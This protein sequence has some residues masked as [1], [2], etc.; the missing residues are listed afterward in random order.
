MQPAA[1]GMALAL[2]C[3]PVHAP[4]KPII[5][6]LTA[7][8][9]TD[10]T[11]LRAHLV[12]QIPRPVVWSDCIEY[13]RKEQVKNSIFIGPGRA[14]A[15]LARREGQMGGW[16]SKDGEPSKAAGRGTNQVGQPSTVKLRTRGGVKQ[17][18]TPGV[19]GPGPAQGPKPAEG[20]Y[21]MEVRAVAT[22]ADY[23]RIRELFDLP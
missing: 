6:G 17:V 5:S 9:V 7:T 22:E 23:G 14:L 19:A 8:P 16:V 11:T 3:V 13:L 10:P 15:N 18:A 21:K 2:S 12:G 20:E 4:R 1:D